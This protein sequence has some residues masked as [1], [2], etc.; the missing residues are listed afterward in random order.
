MDAIFLIHLSFLVCFFYWILSFLSIINNIIVRV[1]IKKKCFL[2]NDYGPWE[3][4]CCLDGL[5]KEIQWRWKKGGKDKMKKVCVCVKNE[6]W[7]F[8][9]WW[10]GEMVKMMIQVKNNNNKK[11]KSEVVCELF[12]FWNIFLFLFPLFWLNGISFEGLTRILW[13]NA[14]SR[15]LFYINKLELPNVWIFVEAFQTM[16]DS[17]L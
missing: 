11:I 7:T 14:L 5:Y 12:L 9:W 13:M 2:S 8:Q 6:T 17:L 15:V 10:N 4:D 1:N 3:D 16:E